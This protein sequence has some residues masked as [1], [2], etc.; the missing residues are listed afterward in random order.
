MAVMANQV[1][2]NNQGIIVCIVDGDQ[3]VQ[4]VNAMGNQIKEALDQAKRDGKHLLLIDDIRKIGKVPTD[5]RNAVVEFEKSLNYKRLA[6]LGNGGVL[7]LGANLIIRA[8]GRARKIRYF[9]NEQDA[10]AWLLS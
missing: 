10:A 1:F 5:A 7:R 3:T 4:S 8:S 9:T 2:T 6:M